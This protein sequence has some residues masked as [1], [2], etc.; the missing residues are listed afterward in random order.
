MDI[1]NFE[2]V[3][4]NT[5]ISDYFLSK[6]SNKNT[7]TY[8]IKYLEYIFQKFKQ[9]HNKINLNKTSILNIASCYIMLFKQLNEMRDKIKEINILNEYNKFKTNN[10]NWI[11]KIEIN[12]I[13][14]PVILNIFI[15]LLKILNDYDLVNKSN[16]VCLD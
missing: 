3:Q 6:D 4:N 5:H 15:S 2:I 1:E 9:Y 16:S 12:E 14:N 10:Y 8:F 7:L 13:K 11:S